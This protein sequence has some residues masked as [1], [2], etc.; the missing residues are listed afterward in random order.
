LVFMTSSLLRDYKLNPRK[1][2]R[3][4]NLLYFTEYNRKT[5]VDDMTLLK[6]K[7]NG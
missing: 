6:K 1:T 4:E 5:L 2:V 7:S 3:V